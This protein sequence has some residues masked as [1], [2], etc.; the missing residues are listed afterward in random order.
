MAD[1]HSTV[2]PPALA[3]L[4]AA[5]RPPGPAPARRPAYRALAGQIRQLVTEGRLPVGARLPAER[6]LATVL[7][8]SRT[9]VATAY[10][11]LR[12]DGYLRSRRGAGSWTTLPEGAPPPGDALHPVPPDEQGRTLDLGVAALPAPQPWLGAA[13]ARAVEQLPYYASGHGHYPTGVPVLREAVARRYTERGLPTTPDQVLITTGAMGGLH[14][15]Q[16]ALVGR[17]DR[18]AV[19]APSYAHTLQALRLSGARLVPVPYAYRTDHRPGPQ[20]ALVPPPVWDRDEWQRVLRGA[21][22]KLA[23]VIP[24]FHNPT[25]ALIDEEQRRE[26]LAAARAAGSIVLVDETTAELDWGVPESEPM[27]RP[28][29]ALDRAAQVVTVGSAG[30]LLWGGLRIGWVRAAPALVRRLAGERVYSDVGT[31]VLEQLIA[32]ELLGEPLPAV[33]AHQLDRL[34]ATAH[35]FAAALPARLPGWSFPMPT[36]GLALWVS[37]DGLSGATLAGVGERDGVRIASGNRFGSDGAFE[38]HIR[39]P[40][41]VPAA[42]VPA[43]VERLAAVAARAAAGG[44]LGPGDEA[45]P[46][47]V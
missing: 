47:A 43:A 4:L 2:T 40:L 29:A 36:G 15:I 21:A 13:A 18:V 26:L 39:I 5:T 16:R 44:R 27:P 12:G 6:E 1:W 22:P 42:A 20:D 32:A 37:T 10:E 46:L 9:T 23:Y 7:E 19:E 11:T 14:L 28:M 35:A 38:Q 45:Q 34:R 17:G 24:D 3:R 31:P 25:G 30:K 8:L 41:T 33:R